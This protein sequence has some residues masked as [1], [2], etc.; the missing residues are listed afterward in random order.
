MEYL[1]NNF[2]IMPIYVYEVIGSSSEDGERFE[3]HQ[4]M[5]EDALTHHPDNG[6]PIR[7]VMMPPNLATKYTPGQTRSKIENKNVEKAGFTKY[8]RDKLT[9]RYHRTAGKQ[10]PATIEAQN[11]KKNQ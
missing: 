7:R 3:I 6:K 4:S 10:G 9:G 5:K 2:I 1:L 8:E 11:L